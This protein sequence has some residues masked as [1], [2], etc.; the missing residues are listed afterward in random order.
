MTDEKTAPFYTML[1]HSAGYTPS[2][3]ISPTW[4]ALSDE[5]SLAFER[6]FNPTTLESSASVLNEIK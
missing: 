3:F 6:I 1:E 4:S 2:A 5:L